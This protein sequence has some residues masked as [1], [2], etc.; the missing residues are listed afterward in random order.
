MC[1]CSGRAMQQLQRTAAP[2]GCGCR[3]G[4]SSDGSSSNSTGTNNCWCSSF[5]C[6]VL[7]D[8]QWRVFGGRDEGLLLQPHTHAHTHTHPSLEGT[9]WHCTRAA[10]GTRP[11]GCGLMCSAHCVAKAVVL[12]ISLLIL[13]ILPRPLCVYISLSISLPFTCYSTD[14]LPHTI[15]RLILF[16]PL[17]LPASAPFVSLGQDHQEDCA[18]AAVLRVQAVFNEAHQGGA[19][20]EPPCVIM[21]DVLLSVLLLGKAICSRPQN[22]WIYYKVNE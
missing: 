4:S 21:L 8:L 13:F 7:S 19:A 5:A 14:S 18:E 20:G 2:A 22:R 6:A 11:C 3:S 9:H 12:C 17:C 15:F 1:G 16:A 10:L